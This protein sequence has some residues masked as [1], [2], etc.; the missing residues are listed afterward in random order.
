MIGRWGRWL[1]LI[2]AGVVCLLVLAGCLPAMVQTVTAVPTAAILVTKTPIATR[3]P[4]PTPTALALER[5][6]MVVESPGK[7]RAGDADVLRLSLIMDESGRITPTAEVGGHAVSGEPVEIP[8]LYDTYNVV[9]EARLDMAGLEV[10]PQGAVKQPMQ[11]GVPVIFVWSLSPDH[12]GSFRGMLWLYLNLIPKAGGA[13]DQRALLA[14]PI[15]IQAVTVLGMSAP[16]ARWLGAIG[17][18]FSFV[19]GIPFL[20]D[21]LRRFWKR[22]KP[23]K[24][25]SGS[26]QSDGAQGG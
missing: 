21:A 19:F 14:R 2:I 18:V 7:I 3:I 5:R 11:P 16:F 6:M 15:E 12:P 9:A 24:E 8:N 10:Q 22:R 23:K 4:L 17:S 20:E 1:G 13:Q 25:K 26:V